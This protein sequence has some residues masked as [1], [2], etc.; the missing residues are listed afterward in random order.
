MDSEVLRTVPK[1][2]CENKH[3]EVPCVVP[4]LLCENKHNEVP[5]AE[6]KLPCQ[7]KDSENVVTYL[8][9]VSQNTSTRRRVLG[10]LLRLHY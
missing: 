4:K 5:C 6:P 8:F 1:L 7:R 9:R 3:S 2:P 10:F